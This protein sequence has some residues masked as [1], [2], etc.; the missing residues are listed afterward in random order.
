MQLVDRTD[1]FDGGGFCDICSQKIVGFDDTDNAF[2]K[3][4]KK[5]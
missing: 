5:N 4:R 2:E 1:T 3:L